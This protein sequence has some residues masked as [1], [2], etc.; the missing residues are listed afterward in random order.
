M[1]TYRVHY[2]SG[3]DSI[4]YRDVVAETTKEAKE[5]LYQY[6]ENSFAAI[7]R[8]LINISQ[9]ELLNGS[10]KQLELDF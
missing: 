5:K 8:T 1:K 7:S 2:Y 9:V 3:Y 6:F 10:L 4:L